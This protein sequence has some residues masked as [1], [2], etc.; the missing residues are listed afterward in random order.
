MRGGGEERRERGEK[1]KG[2]EGGCVCVHNA[3]IM[4]GT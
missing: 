3:V 2:E 1:R 4:P